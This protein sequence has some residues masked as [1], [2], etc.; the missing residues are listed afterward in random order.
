[1]LASPGAAGA[2]S[3]DLG[4]LGI[5]H[6]FL[7][8]KENRTYDQLLGD[9]PGANGDPA[10]AIYGGDIS[11]NHHQL[12]SEFVTLDNFYASG[13]VS[14]DGHLW[15]TQA[16][17]TDYIERSASAGFP[18]TYPYSGEDPLAFASSGFIW[19]NARRAGLTVRLFGEF[20]QPVGAYSR[21]WTE[22]FQDAS[23]PQ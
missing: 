19:D 4:A 5:R 8:I 14:P 21:T 22:Y 18:R 17:S 23:A 1:R 15:I 12:A 3:V 2:N 10:L 7:I 16:M 20:T 6:V 9:V 11:P 13:V